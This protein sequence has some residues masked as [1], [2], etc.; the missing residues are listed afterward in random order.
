MS[1]R[2]LLAFTRLLGVYRA[3]EDVYRARDAGLGRA[4]RRLS[5]PRDTIGDDDTPALSVLI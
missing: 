2:L 4:L 1:E 3:V 5:R